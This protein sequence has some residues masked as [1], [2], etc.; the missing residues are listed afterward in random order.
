M[1]CFF[2]KKMQ[3]RKAM[4]LEALD[5]ILFWEDIP[6]L[7]EFV[8]ERYKQYYP[9]DFKGYIRKAILIRTTPDHVVEIW[10]FTVCTI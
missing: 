5:E 10:F 8:S 6:L 2:Y 1:L 9:H 3:R 4:I 7:K